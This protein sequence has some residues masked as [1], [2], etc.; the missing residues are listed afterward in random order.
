M[1]R[2]K[3]NK[4]GTV[5]GYALLYGRSSRAIRIVNGEIVGGSEKKNHSSK[6]CSKIVEY[7]QKSPKMQKVQKKYV[8]NETVQKRLD[9]LGDP[10]VFRIGTPTSY[11][12]LHSPVRHHQLA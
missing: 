7:V 10:P 8:M 5:Q 4:F 11:L 3:K 9:K 2:K 6:K 12:M 1:K